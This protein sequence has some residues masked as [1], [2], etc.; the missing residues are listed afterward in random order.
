LE[1]SG[2]ITESYVEEAGTVLKRSTT[3]TKVSNAFR[4]KSVFKE[5]NLTRPHKG[6][7]PSIVEYCKAKGQFQRNTDSQCIFLK[8]IIGRGYPHEN[9]LN[10]LR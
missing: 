10:A 9:V 2:Y 6:C 8:N 3:V 4:R 1:G 7:Y 5:N